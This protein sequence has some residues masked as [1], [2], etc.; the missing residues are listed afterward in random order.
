[1]FPEAT[2]IID[3]LARSG[4]G[5][6]AEYARI[7]EMATLPNVIMKFSG[8]RYSSRADYPYRDVRPLICQTYDA[9]GP[10]R[11]IWGGLGKNID[12]YKLQRDLFE[13]SFA[14]ISEA[15]KAKV[16]G[17]TAMRLFWPG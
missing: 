12:D 5:T 14:F 13:E 3:H 8:V 6:P 11:M 9:F 7:L 15:E 17:S 16:R 10:D 4:F 1:M 2:F